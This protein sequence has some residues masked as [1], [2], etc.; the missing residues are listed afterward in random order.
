MLKAVFYVVSLMAFLS[1][2]SAEPLTDEEAERLFEDD[3]ENRAASVNEGKLEF[4]THSP[5]KAVHHHHNTLTITRKSITSGWINMH[6]CHDNLDPVPAMEIVFRPERIKELA[7]ESFVNIENATVDGTSIQL[8]NVSAHARICIKGVARALQ[9]DGKD[10]VLRSGPFMRKFLDGYYPMR[11]SM[12]IEFPDTYLR[13]AKIKPAAQPGFRFS[14]NGS[15]IHFD[16]LFEGRL[17]T[18]VRF[19][20]I[21]H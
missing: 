7:I 9:K 4:L 3:W 16:A 1:L 14:S 18:E 8:T 17:H 10:L 11:V 19:S 15:K 6:Q 2:S 13:F 20:P 12:D 5:V 21:I